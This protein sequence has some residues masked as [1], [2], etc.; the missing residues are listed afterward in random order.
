MCESEVSDMR[1][2]IYPISMLFLGGI[3]TVFC[4]GCAAEASG[5]AATTTGDRGAA[6]VESQAIIL[7]PSATTEQRGRAIR[8][9]REQPVCEPPELWAKAVTDPALPNDVRYVATKLLVQRFDPTG[10]DLLAWV[11]KYHL[12]AW[13]TEQDVRDETWAKPTPFHDYLRNQRNPLYPLGRKEPP[14]SI[15]VVELPR[16]ADRSQAVVWFLLSWQ[17]TKVDLLAAIH[18]GGQQVFEPSLVVVGVSVE[19]WPDW[20]DWKWKAEFNGRGQSPF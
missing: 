10:H 12:E 20:D 2:I 13:F 5:P 14:F 15:F 19:R 1:R 4:S 16:A 17:V 6:A 7:D 18:N 8:V 3:L 9:L 11:R